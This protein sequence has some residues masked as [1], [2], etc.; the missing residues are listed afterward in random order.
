MSFDEVRFELIAVDEEY[1]YFEVYTKADG[2]VVGTICVQVVK[3][4][5]LGKIILLGDE[6]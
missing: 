4:L 6:K 3:P 5:E 1:M 2:F